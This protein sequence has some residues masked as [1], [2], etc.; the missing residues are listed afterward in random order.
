MQGDDTLEQA[1]ETVE[2]RLDEA[3]KAAT[4]VTR[5]L[6]KARAAA[7]VGQLRDLRR[8]VSAAETAA[9]QLAAATAR[10]GEGFDFDDQSYL[11]SGDYAKELLAT[12]AAAR[13]GN[14]RGGR[15]AAV[16]PV[17]GTG[18]AGRRGRRGR[19]GPGPAGCVRP[20]WSPRCGGAAAGSPVQARAVPRQPVRGL[21]AGPGAGKGRRPARS[22][23]WSTCGRC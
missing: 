9:D 18:P 8:L 12:A 16:L 20:C 11:A 6:R 15:A 13:R 19:P 4:A 2:R 23:G 14:V 3:A 5:E 1:L 10:A 7:R 17:A 22:S 21:P